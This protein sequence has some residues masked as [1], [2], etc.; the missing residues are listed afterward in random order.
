MDAIQA[1]RELGKAIQEDERYIHMQ[2]AEQRNEADHDLQAL[3]VKF[4]EGRKELSEEMQKPEKD[5]AK[6]EQMNTA[7]GQV[8]GEIF[9]N[10]NMITYTQAQNELQK[11]IGFVNQIVTGSAQGQNPDIIEYEESCGGSCSSCSGCS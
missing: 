4:N 8:Y 1:A 6:I 10:E 7:L 2:L 5:K 11:M 3:I 9:K